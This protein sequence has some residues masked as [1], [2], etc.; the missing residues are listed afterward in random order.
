MIFNR[1][2]NTTR[3]FLFGLAYKLLTIIGPFI[4]RTIIIYK[5][6]NEYC[7]LSSL[8]TSV[9]SILNISE[10]GIGS[11]IAF[12]L[13]KPVADDDKK[14]VCALLSLLRRLYKYIGGFILLAGI[15]II[16]FLKF[17]I[18][19]TIPQSINIYILYLIYLLNASASY[20]G[21]AYKRTLFDVYQRGD[22]VH[23]IEI[24]AEILKY[25]T[26]IMVL[27]VF[28]DYYVYTVLLL[29]STIFI[30]ISTQ[31]LSKKYYPDLQPAGEVSDEIKRVVKSK[32]AYLAG[33]S[34]AAKLINSAD[35]I[36]ISGYI[37]LSAVGIY[38]NYNYISTAVTG[39]LIIAY[40]AL[41]P[42]IG[43]SLCSENNTR[44]IELFDGLHFLLF[45]IITFCSTCLLC[46]Y[47]PFMR[48]WVGEKSLLDFSVVIMIV[49]FFYSNAS[50][51]LLT[52][53][54]GAAGLWNKTIF[55]Q[56]SAA[57]VNVIMDIIMVKSY[58][59]TGIVFA[60]FITN[61]VISLPMDVYVVNKYV[62][63]TNFAS[64]ML[65][66]AYCVIE[67]SIIAFA[68]FSA[69]RLIQGNTIGSFLIKVIICIIV[70]N[71]ILFICSYKTNRFHYIKTHIKNLVRH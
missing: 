19:G 21:F 71:A 23:K 61:A 36:V 66:E 47:Q 26:Q 58:G 37:G 56:I 9:L 7:G 65:R 17:F 57:G 62:L 45:W 13:Y 52:S 70:P 30:T 42:A 11:A 35:N 8:F 53:Y 5:L 15:L 38:G 25:S 12:C 50:R 34:I 3:T 63:K 40:Q 4:T 39:M 14:V 16:P 48:I 54:V 28:A 59:I 64:G 33:H 27:I 31:L 46:L 10:L 67:T 41:M 32:V 22:V 29:L 43:N 55:R 24:V 44:N 6:G 49:L 51:Q 68:T 2:K 60:S 18:K 69:C 1:T 20:M